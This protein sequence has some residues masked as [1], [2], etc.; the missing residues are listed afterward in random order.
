MFW[1]LA[2]VSPLHDERRGIAGVIGIF[3]DN[4]AKIAT[5]QRI[6]ELEKVDGEKL[7]SIGNRYR[8]LTEGSF[9]ALGDDLIQTSKKTGGNKV[10]LD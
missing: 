7:L 10:T 5:L 6:Q 2:R 8:M 1:F 3:S 9:Y 4:S